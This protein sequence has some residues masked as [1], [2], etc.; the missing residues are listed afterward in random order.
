MSINK[1]ILEVLVLHKTP[2]H[3]IFMMSLKNMVYKIHTQK[4]VI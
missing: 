2:Y 4:K 1:D 3:H